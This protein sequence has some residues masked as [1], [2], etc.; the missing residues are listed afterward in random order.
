MRLHRASVCALEGRNRRGWCVG[1]GPPRVRATLCQSRQ[2]SLE[3]L[4]TLKGSFDADH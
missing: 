3:L 2:G 4:L 1:V